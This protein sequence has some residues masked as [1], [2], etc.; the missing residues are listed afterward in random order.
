MTN[1][2]VRLVTNTQIAGNLK[3]MFVTPGLSLADVLQLLLQS[4]CYGYN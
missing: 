4:K 3:V 1:D 2:L